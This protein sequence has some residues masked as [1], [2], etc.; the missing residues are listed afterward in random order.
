MEKLF[1]IVTMFL[2]IAVLQYFWS[3]TFYRFQ[4]CI[5][6]VCFLFIEK[7]NVIFSIISSTKI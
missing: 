3:Q 5:M 2:N 7:L 4:M 6:H 1:K